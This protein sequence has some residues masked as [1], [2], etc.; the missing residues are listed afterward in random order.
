MA[1]LVLSQI[2]FSPWQRDGQKNRKQMDDGKSKINTIQFPSDN[3]EEE[4][5]CCTKKTLNNISIGASAKQKAPPPLQ[6][7]L[8]LFTLAHSP[9]PFTKFMLRIPT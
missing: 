7:T 9:L 6:T 4:N 5:V 8:I 3:E 2:C 1:S